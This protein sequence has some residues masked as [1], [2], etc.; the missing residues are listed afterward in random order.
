M[1]CIPIQCS[2]DEKVEWL[3]SYSLA[4]T[5]HLIILLKKSLGKYL[6][7]LHMVGSILGKKGKK[8]DEK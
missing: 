4:N 3:V 1:D 5:A 6:S 8:I 7:F 2:I